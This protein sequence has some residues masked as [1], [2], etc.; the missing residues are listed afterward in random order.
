MAPLGVL[1]LVKGKIDPTATC[2]PRLGWHLFDPK[3]YFLVFLVIY[4]AFMVVLEGMCDGFISG[5]RRFYAMTTTV[6]T[7]KAIRYLEHCETQC[8]ALQKPEEPTENT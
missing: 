5:F 2:G 8:G 6:A 1:V 3:P 7:D 4:G